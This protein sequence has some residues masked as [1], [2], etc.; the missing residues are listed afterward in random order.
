MSNGYL[1]NPAIFLVQT[2]FGLYILAVVL[3][4][5]FQWVRADFYNPVS[6]LIVKMTHPVLRPLRRFVPPMLGLDSA[7]LLL[8]WLLKAIE[9][10]LVLL[11]AGSSYPL[12]A[13]LLWSIPALIELTLN[14]FLFAVIIQAVLSWVSPDPYNPVNSLLHSLTDPILAPLQRLIPPVSG[15]DL[16]PMAAIISLYL[17]EMLLMPPLRMVTGMPQGL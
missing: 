16:S 2:L 9:I 17:L 15:V 14:I 13:P 8:A 7:S 11:L 6:Q 1:T 3:R 5:L 10:A 4:L 12:W